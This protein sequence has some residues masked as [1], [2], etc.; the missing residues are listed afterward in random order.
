MARKPG[1]GRGLGVLI[2]E[3]EQ[4]PAP[5]EQVAV[6]SNS[7]YREVDITLVVANPNQPRKVFDDES[8]E[9]LAASIK[10]VGLIQPIIVRPT[11]GDN[12]ELIAGERRLRASIIA[13]L[14]TIPVLVQPD[15]TDALSLEHAIVE[16][17]HRVD[18]NALEE[19][20]AFQQ[21][22]DDFSLTHEQV[23]ER[24]GK[25]RATVTN[26]LRLLQLGGEAQAALVKGSISAG[27]AR[28]LLAVA[29]ATEQ[30]SLVK[31]VVA[32]EWSVRATEEAVKAAT[33]AKT[34][35]T[36]STKPA[37]TKPT[38]RP[39][40]DANIVELERL[41]E[42]YLDTRVHVELKGKQGKISIEFADLDDLERIYTEIAKPK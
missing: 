3:G 29:D 27:H 34:A 32:G 39:V 13:G 8:L 6:A 26:T 41:L 20:A 24:V 23:A 35:T 7:P 10:A 14:A 17:L 1:L 40:P 12:F 22:I 5:V 2:P 19:A 38:L 33:E 9:G 30:A 37:P 4:A 15:V 25:S 11:D 16:N 42:D 21:L 18:L 28:T 31:K 36:G